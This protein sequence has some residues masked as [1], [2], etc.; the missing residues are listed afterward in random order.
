VQ[1]VRRIQVETPHRLAGELLVDTTH[2]VDRHLF[3]QHVLDG[4]IVGLPSVSSGL[5]DQDIIGFS[6]RTLL[7]VGVRVGRFDTACRIVNRLT[8][9]RD[10]NKTADGTGAGMTEVTPDSARRGRPPG[11]SARALEVIALRL[12]T[13]KGFEQTTVEQIAA[14]AGV[15]RRTFFRYYDTKADVLW[16]DFD[17][18]VQ[19]LRAAFAIIPNRTPL[20]TAIRQVVVS[21]NRY[22]PRTSRTA[23]PHESHR[24]GTR[25]TRQC[26]T[27]L[28]RLG[29]RCQRLR[30]YRLG[31][32]ATSSTPGHRPH[33][34]RRLPRRI[35]HMDHP[36]RH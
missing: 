21:V 23:R 28:R 29:T 5:V 7:A 13:E 31:Q 3:H 19:A 18:E 1:P 11:T 14:A 36:R 8:S 32:P 27:P 20:M 34:P 6:H 26:C 30:R 15:S 12:F 4:H 10:G 2:A 22:A 33:H 16:H 35:R 9:L 24:I 25:P 17:H